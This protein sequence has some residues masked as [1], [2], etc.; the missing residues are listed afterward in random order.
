MA[1]QPPTPE[2]GS[3]SPYPRRQTNADIIHIPLHLSAEETIRQ[4]ANSFASTLLLQAKLL[5]YQQGHEIVLQKHVE[6][7]RQMITREQQQTWTRA[8]AIAIGGALFG[9]FAAGF[10]TELSTAAR[11]IWLAVY[12][13][14]GFIGV[15]CIFWGLRR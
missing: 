5:A 1:L 9:A 4:E 11:P 8:L 2:Q 13:I 15:S 10:P 7:A 14:I 12:V 3:S 6:D